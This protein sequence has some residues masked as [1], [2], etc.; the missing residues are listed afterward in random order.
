MTG[1]EVAAAATN[2]DDAHLLI[3]LGQ[4][5]GSIHLVEEQIVLCVLVVW[6]IQCNGRERRIDDV[7]DVFEGHDLS[8]VIVSN[9]NR[10]V[11]KRQYKV[12]GANGDPLLKA[13]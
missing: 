9:C 3:I 6:A 10:L 8:P 7:K 13:G 2:D 11:W 5:H 12:S 1:R 4:G